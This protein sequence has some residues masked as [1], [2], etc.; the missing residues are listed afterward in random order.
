M[1]THTEYIRHRHG[2]R[3]ILVVIHEAYNLA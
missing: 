3:H 1:I 2:H